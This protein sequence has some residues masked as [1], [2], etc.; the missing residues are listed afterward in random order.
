MKRDEILALNAPKVYLYLN[1]SDTG[2]IVPMSG[3][4]VNFF[5]QKAEDKFCIC[6]EISWPPLGIVF[7]YDYNNKLKDM[8][9]ITHWGR[10]FTF[11]DKINI[12]IQ[13]PQYIVNT[14]YPL[15]FGNKHEAAQEA[16]KLCWL[17]HI[18]EGSD[19][20]NNAGVLLTTQ[21]KI[22]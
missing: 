16:S 21:R 2:R 19:K 12:S 1:I 22:L 6:S 4:T 14:H 9:E 3:G 15:V 5:K 10:D 20:P 13:L 18:P 8:E 11:Q 7:S 17:L